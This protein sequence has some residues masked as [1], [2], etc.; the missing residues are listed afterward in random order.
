[1]TDGS[2]SALGEPLS[3]SSGSTGGFLG[4]KRSRVLIAAVSV[5]AVLIVAIVAVAMVLFLSS[6]SSDNEPAVCPAQYAYPQLYADPSN[7][8]APWLNPAQL[9]SSFLYG[10]SFLDIDLQLQPF[11]AYAGQIA[12][13]SNVASF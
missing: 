11:S 13:V 5:A 8:W 10:Q 3:G 1:M 2:Y 12:L 4:M 9:W 6:P 7:Q